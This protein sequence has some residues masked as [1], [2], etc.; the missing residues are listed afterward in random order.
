VSTGTERDEL[1]VPK[2]AVDA[3]TDVHYTLESEPLDAVKAVH[4]IAAPVVAAVLREEAVRL[5]RGAPRNAFHLHDRAS[6]DTKRW[7]A[8]RL[9]A[10]A[11]QLD[12]TGSFAANNAGKEQP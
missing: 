10:R 7:V 9:R 1:P 8:S 12:S 11:E 6:N 2:A 5:E 4:A 3:V